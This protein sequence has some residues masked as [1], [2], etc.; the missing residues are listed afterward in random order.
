MAEQL[1][2]IEEALQPGYIDSTHGRHLLCPVC[3][4][5][6]QHWAE[7]FIKPGNDNYE[8]SWGGRGDLLVIPM[9]GECGHEW[10]I[11]IGTHKGYSELFVRYDTDRDQADPD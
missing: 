7:P 2:P 10:D 5:E 6:Y 1:Y 3:G 11:C 4:F 9:R 8:A